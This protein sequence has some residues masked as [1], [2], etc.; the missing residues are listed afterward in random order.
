MECSKTDYTLWHRQL[1]QTL[2]S[3]SLASAPLPP[4]DM[5]FCI[6]RVLPLLTKA[7]TPISM[8]IAVCRI[9]S[10]DKLASVGEL[11]DQCYAVLFPQ[12]SGPSRSFDEGRDVL[13]WKPWFKVI[14]DSVVPRETLESLSVEPLMPPRSVIIAPR[15]H[16]M[17]VR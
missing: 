14:V 17:Q 16:I 9:S 8:H 3:A 4:Y 12:L 7:S 10:R 1:E 11:T 5:R 6:L 13:A 15:W 2:S